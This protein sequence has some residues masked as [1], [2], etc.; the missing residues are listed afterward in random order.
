MMKKYS[1]IQL[2]IYAILIMYLYCDNG[3]LFYTGSIPRRGFKQRVN[4]A[5]IQPLYW[6]TNITK[7]PMKRLV[8]AP[9]KRNGYRQ[10]R[11]LSRRITRLDY[12]D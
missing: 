10:T 9:T 11:R 3:K 6:S 4:C 1:N 7:A 12:R 2:I 8:I 5:R